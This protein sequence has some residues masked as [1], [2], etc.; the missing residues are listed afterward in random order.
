MIGWHMFGHDWEHGTAKVIDRELI[1][2]G[3][4]ETPG[5]HRYVV[6]VENPTGEPFRAEIQDPG[7]RSRGYVVAHVGDEVAV[8]IDRKHQKAKLDK[9]DPSRHSDPRAI[10][11]AT[12]ARLDAELAAAP[13]S[14]PEPA[15]AGTPRI[16]INGKVFEG[17][18]DKAGLQK[19]LR[20]A[21]KAPR[22]D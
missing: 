14:A 15:V 12:K 11:H 21:G 18:I 3:G 17:S 2:S 16:T 13:G 19:A 7:F 9:D 20:E 5:Q 4:G 6:E 1:S 22:G 10:E 8:L